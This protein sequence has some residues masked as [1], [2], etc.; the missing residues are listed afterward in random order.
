MN[1]FDIRCKL[2]YGPE[3]FAVIHVRA[4]N[5]SC[6]LWLRTQVAW[7]DASW[8]CNFTS[9]FAITKI[10]GGNYAA[11]KGQSSTKL[12]VN[13]RHFVADTEAVKWVLFHSHS[14][15]PKEEKVFVDKTATKVEQHFE[16]WPWYNLVGRKLVRE[17]AGFSARASSEPRW[18]K[19]FFIGSAP[20]R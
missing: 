3:A 13:V 6:D 5:H 12:T 11:I 9:Q 15:V 7:P 17:I 8:R 20:N 4:R 2:N 10:V 16:R 1:C 18:Q 19:E 14:K